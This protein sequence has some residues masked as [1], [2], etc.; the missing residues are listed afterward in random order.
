ATGAVLPPGRE[1][2]LVFT[3]L[4]KRAMPLVRYRTGDITTLTLEPCRCGRT[5]ARMARVKGRSDDMLIVKGVNLYP[6]EVERTLL[7]LDELPPHYHL[8]AHPGPTLP[9]LQ[10]H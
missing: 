4:T 8:V 9:P 2:E 10:V 3:T 7:A 1:G 5:S 6:S